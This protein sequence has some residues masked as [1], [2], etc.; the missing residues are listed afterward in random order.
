MS[1]YVVLLVG[2]EGGPTP[3]RTQNEVVA[4][5]LPSFVFYCVIALT[6]TILCVESCDQVYQVSYKFTQKH[7]STTDITF[8]TAMPP[9]YH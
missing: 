7:H 5:V 1:E 4:V 3:T 2:R 9:T 8:I 6:T